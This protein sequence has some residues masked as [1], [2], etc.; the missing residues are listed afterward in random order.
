MKNRAFTLIEL[1]VVI[2]IISLLSSIVMVS[3]NTAR[4]K[5]RDSKR[6]SDMKELQTALELYRL[7]HN[8]YPPSVPSCGGN[9]CHFCGVPNGIAD[10]LQPLVDGKYISKLP[11]DPLSGQDPDCFTYEYM[12]LREEDGTTGWGCYDNGVYKTIDQ[13]GYAIRFETEEMSLNWPQ[14][15]FLRNNGHEYCATP[16]K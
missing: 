15:L 12:S 14:F 4:I 11:Q 5:G 2:A 1:L 10:A 3:L 16:P 13:Y 7:D 6:L 8:S 9:W